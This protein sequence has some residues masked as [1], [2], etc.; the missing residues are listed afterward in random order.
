[1][2]RLL[3]TLFSAG[4]LAPT[5]R[6]ADMYLRF[7]QSDGWLLLQ[8]GKQVGSFPIIQFSQRCLLAGVI[9]LAAVI[10]YWSW[11]YSA[12]TEPKR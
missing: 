7:W 2:K 5:W 10:I 8:G 12:S 6:A 3:I 9:W 11:K 1:M 4:W